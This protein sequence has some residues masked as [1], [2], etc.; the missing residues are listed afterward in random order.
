MEMLE[1]V[2]KKVHNQEFADKCKNKILEKG[3]IHLVQRYFGL[4]Y[5]A[6]EMAADNEQFVKI[7][8]KLGF[9]WFKEVKQD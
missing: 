5:R 1:A 6:D 9:N 2:C 4:H 7:T 3:Y 8:E